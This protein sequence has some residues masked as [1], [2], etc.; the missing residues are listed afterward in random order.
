V[1]L[2]SVGTDKALIA[3]QYSLFSPIARFYLKTIRME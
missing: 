2:I 1:K 3:A